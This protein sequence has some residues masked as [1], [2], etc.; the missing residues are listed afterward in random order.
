MSLDV[1]VDHVREHFRLTARFSSEPGLTALFGRSGS[2]KTTLVDIIGGLVRPTR[3]R[4]AIDGQ[5]LVDTERGVFVPSHRRRIGYV[6]QD[7]RLF[8]HLSVRKNLLYGRTAARR[9][10]WRLWSNFWISSPCS[11]A[12]PIPFL[13]A[14]SNAWPSAGRCSP[15]RV[16]S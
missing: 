9:R 12:D 7:S 1:D 13:G 14:R 5:V 8:P 2:G 11:N 15:I 3:G 4:I 10:I 6:F 16:S